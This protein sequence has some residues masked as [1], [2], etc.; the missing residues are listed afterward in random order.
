MTPWELSLLLSRFLW[1]TFK[2]KSCLR[3]ALCSLIITLYSLHIH[4]TQK[5][6]NT[7]SLYSLFFFA[8]ALIILPITFQFPE[9]FHLCYIFHFTSNHAAGCCRR[10]LT[11]ISQWDKIMFCVSFLPFLRLLCIFSPFANNEEGKMPKSIQFPLWGL[12]L[13]ALSPSILRNRV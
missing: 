9:F 2:A 3:D 5:N 12:Q 11:I 10:G 8:E 4:F 1:D 6:L 7:P 13:I